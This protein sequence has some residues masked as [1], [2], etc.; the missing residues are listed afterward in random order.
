MLLAID[1]S[2]GTSVAVV[3]RE[4]GILVELT[5]LDTRRHAEVIGTL[6]DRALHE[7]GVGARELTAVAVGMGPGPFTGLR[8][9]I[10]AARVFALGAG[11]PVLPGVSHDAIAYGQPDPVLVITDARR[12]EV[13]WSRYAGSDDAGLPVRAAGPGLI[14]PELL[15]TVTGSAP[16]RR[17][18]PEGVSAGALGLVAEHLSAH[19]RAFAS[20]AALYLRSPD[21][22]PSAGPKRVTG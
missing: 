11:L 12:R 20:D 22:T 16:I 1:T 15:D 7:A 10:A 3:D 5:E 13:Y 8:V 6:I 21:V 17:L 18:E 19:R 4:A 2:A 9:G 14:A